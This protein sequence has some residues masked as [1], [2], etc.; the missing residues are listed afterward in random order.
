MARKPAQTATRNIEGENGA[1]NPADTPSLPS[2]ERPA[3]TGGEGFPLPAEASVPT[4]PAENL[5]VPA[6][7][8][9]GAG[10]PADGKADGEA[11]RIVVTC[12][13]AGGR[14]RLG[15]RWPEGETMLPFGALTARDIAILRGDPR[16][17]VL[18]PAD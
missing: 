9:G 6:A 17:R 15:R 3:A 18:D 11:V 8:A 1:G 16:F 10:G 2:G 12:F 14:R 4:P 7:G 13:A 5:L